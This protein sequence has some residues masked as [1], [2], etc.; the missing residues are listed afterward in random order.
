MF[1]RVQSQLTVYSHTVLPT[2][3][4]DDLIPPTRKTYTGPLEV[5]EDLM[6]IDISETVTVQRGGR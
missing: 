2:A 3:T 5:G 1:A 6:S 4:E